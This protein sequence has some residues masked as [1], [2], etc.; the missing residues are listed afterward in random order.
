MALAGGDANDGR[1]ASQALHS[2]DVWAALLV[3]H[4]AASQRTEMLYAMD[5]VVPESITPAPESQGILFAALRT[6]DWKLVEGMP[7]RDDWYG[8]DPCSLA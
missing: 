8:E 2:H 7:G 6:G 1:P 3:V 4:S 5:S